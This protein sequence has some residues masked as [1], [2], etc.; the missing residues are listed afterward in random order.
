MAPALYPERLRSPVALAF[1]ARINVVGRAVE[2][3]WPPYRM[4][5]PPRH[6]P[7]VRGLRSEGRPGTGRAAAPVCYRPGE[8]AHPVPGG[9]GHRGMPKAVSKLVRNAEIADADRAYHSRAIRGHLRRR[10]IRAAVPQP[11]D[12]IGHRLRRGRA[13]GRPPG[14]D[15]ET[16]EERNTVERCL[17]R[18]KQWRGLAVRTDEL[19]I[20]YRAALQLA[21]THLDPAPSQ[22]IRG[23]RQADR[24]MTSR[25][26]SPSKL[27]AKTSASRRFP[28]E[29]SPHPEVVKDFD[30]ATAVLDKSLLQQLDFDQR[31]DHLS[32][33]HPLQLVPRAITNHNDLFR[34]LD[35]HGPNTAQQR[36]WDGAP[37]A[38][39]RPAACKR[40]RGLPPRERTPHATSALVV[41]ARRRAATS[42][43]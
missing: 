36:R 37:P 29:S 8:Q 3:E 40:H 34:T 17:A 25:F 43:R 9:P 2:T 42:S 18:L 38:R 23:I 35:G 1:P 16:Y 6:Q 21:A 28:L 12:Q 19:T 15:T 10:G 20:V 7:P 24:W 13:G 4:K 27:P 22:G 32:R 11:V 14:F 33:R 39:C 5:P 31:M 30:Q 26:C 41:V